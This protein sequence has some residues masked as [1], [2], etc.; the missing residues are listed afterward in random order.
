[1]ITFQNVFNLEMYLND[2]FLFFKFILILTYQNNIK[3][4]KN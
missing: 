4:Q 2:I 3:S 1:V